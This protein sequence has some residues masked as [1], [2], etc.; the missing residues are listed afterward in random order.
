MVSFNQNLLVFLF[1]ENYWKNNG[2]I[3]TESHKNQA[4]LLGKVYIGGR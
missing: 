4:L 2:T 1:V 3:T